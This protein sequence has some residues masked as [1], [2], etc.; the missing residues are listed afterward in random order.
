MSA[1]STGTSKAGSG[2]SEKVKFLYS[3][4][5]RADHGFVQHDEEKKII[6]YRPT[7]SKQK[8]KVVWV[9][10]FVVL[11]LIITTHRSSLML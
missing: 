5:G 4:A 9:F 11:F 8:K 2:D 1:L 7:A 3:A 6:T 10:D